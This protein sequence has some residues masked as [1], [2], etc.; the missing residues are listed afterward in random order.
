MWTFTQRNVS[1]LVLETASSH[2]CLIR[3]NVKGWVVTEN[4]KRTVSV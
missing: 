4:R 3:H 1:N 2:V